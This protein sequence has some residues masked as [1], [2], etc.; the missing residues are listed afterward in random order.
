M[1]QGDEIMEISDIREIFQ[2][3]VST[4][5][6]GVKIDTHHIARNRQKAIGIFPRAKGAGN[7]GAIGGMQNM[8]YIL[9]RVTMMIR[10]GDDG[11]IAERKIM[12]I[13]N[14]TTEINILYENRK[15]FIQGINSEPVWLGMDERGIYEY[16]IDFDVYVER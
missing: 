16:V 1:R 14:K 4:E 13:F 5:I 2:E 6:E 11:E 7:A 9:R 15:G 12:G 3:L 10:W 8:G